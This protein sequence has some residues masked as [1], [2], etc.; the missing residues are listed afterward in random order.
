MDSIRADC[1]IVGAGPVGM[2]VALELARQGRSV[3]IADKYRRTALHSYALALHPRTLRLLDELGTAERLLE[4][5]QPVRWIDVRAGGEPVAE[6]DVSRV[7]GRFPFVLVVPQ[8]ALEGVLEAALR[9]HDVSVLWEHQLLAFDAR[10]DAVVAVLAAVDPDSASVESSVSSVRVSCSYLVGADGTGSATARLLGVE[11]APVGPSLEYELIEFEGEVRSPDRLHLLL[12]RTTIDV[13][14]PLGPERARFSLQLPSGADSAPADPREL[15]RSRA[16]WFPPL[17]RVEW[18]TT[19]R[20]Q[21]SIASRFGRGRVWLAGDSCHGTSPVGVQSMNVGMREGRDLA[22]RLAERID[23]RGS[24]LLR[25]YNEDRQR[26]WKM[27]LGVKNRI[28]AAP[29]AA[30]W[31]REDASR[32]VASLPA[33]GKDLNALLRQVGLRL[34]W[35]RRGRATRSR[36]R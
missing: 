28:R 16:P 3:A 15:V 31:A 26:E 24:S 33:S 6:I 10:R 1:L 36:S 25:I 7:G 22:R 27:M 29:S 14:W 34:D 4:L 8:T 23:G 9:E 20:F 17:E 11:H 30:V 32:L 21:P 5:G 18:T 12:D 2:V 19:V 35:L 13:L